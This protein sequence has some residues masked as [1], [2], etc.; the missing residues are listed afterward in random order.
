MEKVTEFLKKAGVFYFL[1]IK[2]GKPRG[3]PFGIF[4]VKDNCLVVITGGQKE[5][6][7][8]TKADP[9]VELVATQGMTFWRLDGVAEEFVD[10]EFE[11]MVR[12]KNPF[13]NQLYNEQTGMTIAF[14]YIKN[15]HA[16]FI[17]GNHTDDEFD[18]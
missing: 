14:F 17:T 12:E 6:Y 5:I 16:Q 18:L 1:T 7:K 4:E 3:R 11:K 2:D 8:E 13:M 15:A 10:K 9:H